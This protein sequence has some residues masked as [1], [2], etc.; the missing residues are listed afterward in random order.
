[1]PWLEGEIHFGRQGMSYR[2]YKMD[3][4]KANK[5][6]GHTGDSCLLIHTSWTKQ[7][8]QAIVNRLERMSLENDDDKIAMYHYELGRY[9]EKQKHK[10][11][12]ISGGTKE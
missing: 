12:S 9:D 8:I 11:K 7:M 1:M 6:Y 4:F 3:K 5:L 10:K 2:S